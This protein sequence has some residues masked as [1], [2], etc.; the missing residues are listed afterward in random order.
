MAV[1]P[2]EGENVDISDE[3]SKEVHSVSYD[4]SKAEVIA[5]VLLK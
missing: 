4:I 1:V 3:V 2:R 5:R